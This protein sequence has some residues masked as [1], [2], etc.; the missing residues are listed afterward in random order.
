MKIVRDSVFMGIGRLLCIGAVMASI[1]SVYGV[2]FSSH[3]VGEFHV[4]LC[5]LGVLCT[6]G[7]VVYNV[8]VM[9]LG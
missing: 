3:P 9:V 1:R 6:I 5:V 8:R 4:A 7:A 2:L